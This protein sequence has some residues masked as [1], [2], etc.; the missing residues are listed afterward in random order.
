MIPQL[1]LNADLSDVLALRY[2]YS[3]EQIAAAGLAARVSEAESKK[4]DLIVRAAG[5]LA[6]LGVSL[7]ALDQFVIELLRSRVVETDR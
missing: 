4:A 1:P 5:A 2:R 6:P 7:P 3:R